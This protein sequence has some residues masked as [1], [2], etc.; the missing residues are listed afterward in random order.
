MAADQTFPIRY[1]ALRPL[2]TVLGT[3]PGLSGVVIG[4]DT[5][6][7]RMGWAFRAEIP[8]T[9]ITDVRLDDG[10]VG[11][12]GV[13]GWRGRWLVNGSASGLVAITVDP[14]ARAWTIGFPI[15]LRLLRVSLE[16]PEAFVAA[17]KR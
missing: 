8:L 10:R 2:L 6:S 15:R 14:P 16:D 9:S 12:I 11:G 17:I 13:H 4:A 7:V 5:L 1:G 3:G